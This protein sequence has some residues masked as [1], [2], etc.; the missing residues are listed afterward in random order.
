MKIAYL[1]NQYPQTSHT[2]IRREIAAIEA[3][4]V[5]VLRY[6]LRPVG[7][8]TV[9]QADQAERERTQVLQGFGLRG[10]FTAML[11]V[12]VGRPRRF[13]R[14]LVSTLRM[15][16]RSE[17]GV[18]YHL[19]YL[20]EAC[21]L[22]EW[23]AAADVQHL[24]AHFGTNSASVA[25]LCRILG[26]PRYSV[27]VHGPEEFD[28]PRALSLNEKIRHS[29]FVVAVSE[30]GRSQLCRWA[31]PADWSK[32]RVVRCGV[33]ASFLQTGP[34]AASAS[35]RFVC[36]G[37]LAE[38]KGQLLL[39]EA[40]ALLRDRGREFSITL[41]G[42]GPMRP[43]IEERIGRLG[44][45]DCVR[46]VGWRDGNGVRREI[47]ESR[48][49][50]LPSFA[51]GLPVVLMESLALGRPVVSTYVAGIPELVE[52]GVCGWLVPAG[53]VEGLASAIDQALSAD[54]E[55]LDRMGSA[56]SSRVAS[57]HN[58]ATEANRLITF[59]YDNAR[60]VKTESTKQ[61]LAYRGAVSFTKTLSNG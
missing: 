16:W 20:A 36:V 51:E 35:N 46:L 14:A 27:T 57:H 56:G 41:V 44:L 47:L 21:I 48:A 10:L 50:V 4:G 29:A 61:P 26:G 32:I 1:I 25:M 42:D 17:R 43:L 53:S 18:A 6:T 37:R 8:P 55:E 13:A 9:D 40:A 3:R 58:A 7:G 60:T 49:L 59:I 19:A 38:Q 31:D 34:A 15:G 5:K 2:F 28:A 12:M 30:F 39:V 22:R 52:P 33:D 11:W 45:E 23:L 24:H 54:V